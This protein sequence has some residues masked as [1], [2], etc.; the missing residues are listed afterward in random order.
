MKSGKVLLSV[1]AGAAAGATIGIL[2]APDKGI[3]TRKKISKKGE[4]Y[5]GSLKIKFED[6]LVS[7]TNELEYAKSEAGD[8]LNKG[9]EKAE[10]VKAKAVE[11]KEKAGEIK[12]SVNEKLSTHF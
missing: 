5:L 4:D 3:N 7:A 12:N 9:K 10:D 6:F 11:I 8:L 1:L 2:F